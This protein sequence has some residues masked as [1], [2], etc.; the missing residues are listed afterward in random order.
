MRNRERIGRQMAGIIGALIPKELKGGISDTPNP[1][2]T[3]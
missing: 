2:M 1:K 3:L